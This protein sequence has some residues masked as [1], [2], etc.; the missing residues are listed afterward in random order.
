MIKIKFER[1]YVKRNAADGTIKDVFVHIVTG[2]AADVE[3]YV[4]ATIA[5]GAKAESIKDDKGVVRFYSTRAVP[6]VC[7]L[8]LNKKGQYFP[9][10]EYWDQIRSL[11]QAGHSFEAAK[12]MVAET[13][14]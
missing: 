4:K 10:T 2:D 9:N 8:E 12:A 7:N 5:G 13:A 14:A 11:Q 3:A 1:K 6:G